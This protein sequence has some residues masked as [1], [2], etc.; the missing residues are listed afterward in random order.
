MT[1]EQAG[2][3]LREAVVR[4]PGGFMTD[5]ATYARGAELGFDGADFYLAG[6]A[7]VLGEVAADIVVAALVFFAPETV[8][9]AWDRTDAVM[10]R[11]DAA[12]EWAAVGHAWAIAHFPDEVDWR[13]VGA[14]LGRVVGAAPVAGAPLFAGWRLLRE[15]EE[16]KAL[17]LHRLNALRELRGALHGAAV[18]TVGLTPIE[19][20][21][22]RTPGMLKVFGWPEPHPDPK[23][24]HD[25]WGLAE[26]RTDRMFGRHLAV[27][28]DDE[29][30]EL[31]QVLAP[32]AEPG[33]AA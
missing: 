23:P 33:A 32:L 30:A 16:V 18:L 31:V 4:I 7:G 8:H 22:V 24:L 25:R 20:I 12:R 5:P 2:H 1:P 27:L 6:R 21:V 14:L 28:D 19:A 17:A 29:R 10:T 26:A 11:A 13:T 9:A 15:P 3:E